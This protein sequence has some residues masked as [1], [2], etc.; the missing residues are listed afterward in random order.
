MISL[1]AFNTFD[2]P[3]LTNCTQRVPLIDL[4]SPTR[5]FV[6]Y[7]SVIHEVFTAIITEFKCHGILVT[8]PEAGSNLT[9]EFLL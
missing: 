6:D 4:E 8:H 9:L 1:L 7:V 5:Y 2:Y 3:S